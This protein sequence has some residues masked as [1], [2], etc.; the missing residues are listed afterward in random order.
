MVVA[1][2]TIAK[3]PLQL[4][5]VAAVM[6]QVLLLAV[7]AVVV[8]VAVLQ[9]AAA[10]AIATLPVRQAEEL[11]PVRKVVAQESNC[12]KKVFI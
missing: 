11:P 7:A 2:Q 4:E 10:V 5:A 6:I 12:S 9:F 8:A 1:A 3:L